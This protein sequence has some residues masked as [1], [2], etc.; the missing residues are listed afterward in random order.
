[1][2]ID[3]R[4]VQVATF[5]TKFESKSPAILN[6]VKN[7]SG[8]TVS[9]IATGTG[10]SEADVE[11]V[12][13]V[14]NQSSILVSATGGAGELVYW[15]S[16]DWAAALESNVDDARTWQANHN[17][18]LMTQMAADLGLPYEIAERLGWILEYE[19]T[20]KRADA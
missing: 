5:Q 14:L 9:E 11:I 1:M 13:R 7:N 10:E 18:A 16:S 20:S 12:L 8:S 2:P 17:G 4:L 6:Y 15:H 19:G 3:Y